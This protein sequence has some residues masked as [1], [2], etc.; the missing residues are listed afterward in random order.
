M[1]ATAL[2]RTGQRDKAGKYWG[3]VC[4]Y[5]LPRILQYDM[6]DGARADAIVVLRDVFMDCGLSAEATKLTGTVTDNGMV[7]HNRCMPEIPTVYTLLL[8]NRNLMNKLGYAYDDSLSKADFNQWE[9]SRGISFQF[10]N[11][12]TANKMI[13]QAPN[14]QS[15][16]LVSKKYDYHTDDYMRG[17]YIIDKN[18]NAIELKGNTG[19]ERYFYDGQNRLHYFATGFNQETRSTFKVDYDDAGRP[20]TVF[21]EIEL[22][23]KSEKRYD[24]AY[25]DNGLIKKITYYDANGKK[26]KFSFSYKKA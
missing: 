21:A 19:F 15:N 10:Y 25:D 16:N 20:A 22:P 3:L 23:H 5:F 24:I 26:N 13:W 8:R 11:Y 4:D 2:C 12:D 7:N 1:Y 18:G 14:P 17:K 6:E 9:M